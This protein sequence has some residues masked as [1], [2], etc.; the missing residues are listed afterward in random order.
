[1]KK[2]LIKEIE[3]KS[4]QLNQLK[5]HIGKSEVCSDIYDK[6]L[7]ER[8]VLKKQLEDLKKKSIVNR[9]KNLLPKNEKLICDYF[10]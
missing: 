9:L 3:K 10:K 5:E 6:V 1:M 4:I 2:E 7:I 8:A